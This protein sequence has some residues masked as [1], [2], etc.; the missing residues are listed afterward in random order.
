QTLELPAHAYLFRYRDE[1][2]YVLYCIWEDKPPAEAQPT[3]WQ[4]LTSSRRMHDVWTGR[5]NLGQQV[6]E[7]AVLGPKD[8]PSAEAATFQLLN[9]VIRLRGGEESRSGDAKR[10]SALF[11]VPS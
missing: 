3:N 7:V 10:S 9:E 11:N 8:V 1:P 5:R 6:L 4:D 2:L